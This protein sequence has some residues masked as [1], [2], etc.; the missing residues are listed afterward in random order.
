MSFS[1]LVD[2]LLNRNNL[3]WKGRYD[4]ARVSLKSCI[5]NCEGQE[6]ELKAI[7][8]KVFQ[9]ERDLAPFRIPPPKVSGELD[10]RILTGLLNE[11]LGTECVKRISDGNYK[12]VARSEMER[13]LKE[14]LTDSYKYKGNDYDCDDFSFRLMG[15]LSAPGWAKLATGIIWGEFPKPHAINCFVD[16]KHTFWLIEPQ[17]D[18]IF[19][20]PHNWKAIWVAI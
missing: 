13:F 2:W 1:R 18:K 20:M 19:R 4:T 11:Q 7:R 17:N 6:E 15:M 9:L 14:D 10:S 5:A 3:Y 16:S 12:L 8:Q